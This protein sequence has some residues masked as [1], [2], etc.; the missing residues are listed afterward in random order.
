[1]LSVIKLSVVVMSLIKLIFVILGVAILSLVMLIVVMPNV[2]ILIII[3]QTESPTTACCSSQSRYH[4]TESCYAEL[5][6]L[7]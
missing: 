3:R 2:T 5:V 1:M 4:Y 7:C 6:S